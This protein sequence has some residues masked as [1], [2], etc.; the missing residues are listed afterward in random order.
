[1]NKTNKQKF[2]KNNI[3][4]NYCQNIN[5]TDQKFLEAPE[6]SLWRAVITQ[7]LM[8]AASRSQKKS[9]IAHKM[10]ALQWLLL[11][12]EFFTEV[13]H[14]ADFEPSVLKVI[15]EDVLKNGCKWRQDQRSNVVN[16]ELI[17]LVN[18]M[19]DRRKIR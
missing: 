7:A 1:M 5:W 19:L 9:K 16:Q 3:Q 17:I 10:Q 6:K 12:D 13:C 8:D 4:S 18:F 11:E 15:I 14:Y 2:F